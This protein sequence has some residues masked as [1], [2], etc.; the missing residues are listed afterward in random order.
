MLNDFI[1]SFIFF[2]IGK[3]LCAALEFIFRKKISLSKGG[4]IVVGMVAPP[5][6]LLLVI[7]CDIF[8]DWIGRWVR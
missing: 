3:G 6:L 5:T 1:I 4:Y 8:Y 7:Y 2:W